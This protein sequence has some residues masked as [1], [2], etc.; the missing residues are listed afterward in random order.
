MTGKGENKKKLS[1]LEI[2]WAIGQTDDELLLE[3]ESYR[4][5]P[6]YKRK[7]FVASVSAAACFALIITG[8]ALSQSFS[9]KAYKADES[10]MMQNSSEAKSEEASQ[11]KNEIAEITEAETAAET[12]AETAAETPEE[13]CE[14]PEIEAEVEEIDTETATEAKHELEKITLSEINV[15]GMGFEGLLFYDDEDF[16]AHVSQVQIS[17]ETM[18]VYKNLSY[19]KYAYP[20]GMTYSELKEKFDTLSRYFG[21]EDCETTEY[22]Y[23][24]DENGTPSDIVTSISCSTD[25]LSLCVRADGSWSVLF[26]EKEAVP[27]SAAE[28]NA[29]YYV[30][31]YSDLF[32]FENPAVSAFSDRDI[33]GEI[34]HEYYVVYNK[35]DDETENLI[36]MTYSYV[37]PILYK[38]GTFGGFHVS[39]GM[40][41]K[42]KLGDYP[43]ITEDEA[44]NA[45]IGGRYIT[46]VPSDFYSG[47][48]EENI[49]FC[50]MTYR[51]SNAE[52]ALI[53]YYRFYVRLDKTLEGLHN[54]GAFYVPAIKE[55][56]IANMEIFDG[57]FN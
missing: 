2:F 10:V 51:E 47:I 27:Y 16:L 55:E 52:E 26:G 22:T 25:E 13:E 28:E 12:V 35:T 43:I 48:T 44:K 54:Y 37:R 39:G 23:P 3:C 4:A 40:A 30:E 17:A 53:P 21:V 8:A 42:E 5:A 38:D 1:A 15:G 19:N 45:L 29:L 34:G 6:L 9:D 11:D 46:T 20:L 57:R 14:M 33:Y 36:G 41:Y 7:S 49:V 18:P 50:E 31:K 32:S 56:Y 24:L